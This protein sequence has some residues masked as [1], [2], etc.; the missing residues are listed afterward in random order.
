[1]EVA[2]FHIPQKLFPF[3]HR[4]VDVDGARVHYVDEGAGETLS[5]AARQPVVVLPLSEDIDR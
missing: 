3:R 2:P 5:A 1:M 4:F